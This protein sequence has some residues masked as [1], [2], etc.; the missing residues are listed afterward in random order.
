MSTKHTPGPWEYNASTGY[1]YD[2]GDRTVCDACQ[3]FDKD[4]S[5]INGRL[6]AAAPE[7]LEFVAEYIDAWKSGMAG[8]SYLLRMADQVFAKAT[9]D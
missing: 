9:G 3:S 6:I 8:D 2:I 1:V 5:D 7:L 4:Q